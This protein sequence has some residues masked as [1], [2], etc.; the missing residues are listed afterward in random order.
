MIGEAEDLKSGIE[1]ARALA[2]ELALVDICLPD[3]DGFEL[4]S[5][6]LA[7]EGSA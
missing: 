5:R 4:S 7:L 3:A 6:L 1:A 2:P